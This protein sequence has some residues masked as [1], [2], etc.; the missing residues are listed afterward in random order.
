MATPFS[1]LAWGMPWR[2]SLVGCSP[3]GRKGVGHSLVT[4]QQLG[5]ALNTGGLQI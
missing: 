1:I 2:G 3:W 4:E 5:P